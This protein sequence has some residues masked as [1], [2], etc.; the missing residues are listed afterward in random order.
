MKS[1]VRWCPYHCVFYIHA[2][3][4]ICCT[5][6]FVFMLITIKY[7]CDYLIVHA[8]VVPFIFDIEARCITTS[9]FHG[10]SVTFKVI[11]FVEF[12]NALSLSTVIRLHGCCSFISDVRIKWMM[13]TCAL[14]NAAEKNPY[15]FSV[16]TDCCDHGGKLLIEV[17]L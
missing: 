8:S 7:T 14:F 15:Q 12:D 16:F 6:P 1:K 17:T 4:L 13:W 3:M 5:S 11:P 10:Y 2:F 9:S